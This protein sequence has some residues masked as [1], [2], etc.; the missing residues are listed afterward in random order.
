MS[1]TVFGMSDGGVQEWR[2]QT[3]SE[4]V[5]F[6]GRLLSAASSDQPGRA[7]W[8]EIRIYQTVDDRF[9][10]EGVGGTRV[11][12]ERVRRWVIVCA[13]PTEVE[14]RLRRPDRATGRLALGGVSREALKRAW[15]T[16]EC[17]RYRS[18]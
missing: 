16:Y 14:R 15:P 3:G 9:V 8:T 17:P 12:G 6:S 10:V 1:R 13:D 18:A 4:V 2:V 7:R 5:S 11:V